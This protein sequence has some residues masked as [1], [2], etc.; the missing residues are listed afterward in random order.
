MNIHYIHNQKRYIQVGDGSLV[1][2]DQAIT[3]ATSFSLT[4]NQF[5][6]VYL[7]QFQQ[8]LIVLSSG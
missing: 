2:Q 6:C 4:N 1:K 3:G 7:N 8:E 5:S